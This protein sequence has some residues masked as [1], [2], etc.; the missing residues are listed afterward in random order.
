[1]EVNSQFFPKANYS[2][3]NAV[4]PSI[5]LSTLKHTASVRIKCGTQSKP[6]TCWNIDNYW[7][8]IGNGDGVKTWSWGS[9]TRQQASVWHAHEHTQGQAGAGLEVC[10]WG[11]CS[12]AKSKSGQCRSGEP[13]IKIHILNSMYVPPEGFKSEVFRSECVEFCNNQYSHHLVKWTTDAEASFIRTPIQTGNGL[14]R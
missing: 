3:P 6:E 13:S 1:M 4:I 2:K 8:C 5:T 12:W 14:G 11:L 10:L 7:L 9:H